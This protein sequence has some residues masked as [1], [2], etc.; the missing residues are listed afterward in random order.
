MESKFEKNLRMSF[1]YVKRDLIRVNEQIE[2]LNEKIRHLSMNH[3][4]L[5][6]EL[7]RIEENALGKKKKTVR[8]RKFK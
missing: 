3:A 8:V 2:A 6:G 4:S 5:L 7:A 1:S